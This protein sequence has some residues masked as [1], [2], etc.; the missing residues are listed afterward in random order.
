VLFVH[1]EEMLDDLPGVVDRV[2]DFLGQPLEADERAAVV[3]RSRFESMKA[4]EEVFEMH[5]PSP[6]SEGGAFLRS[7]SRQRHQDV[8]S[9]ESERIL[10][11]CRERLRGA[12]YPAARFYPDLAP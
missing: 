6:F 12:T 8:G 10:A 7:G 11:F 1:Y 4:R 5:P 2:A 3:E 9:A